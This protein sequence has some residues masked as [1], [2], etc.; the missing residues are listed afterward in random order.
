MYDCQNDS[1]RDFAYDAG[2]TAPTQ[3]TLKGTLA[4]SAAHTDHLATLEQLSQFA[5]QRGYPLRRQEHLLELADVTLPDA[6]V[7]NA[8]FGSALVI[9]CDLRCHPPA[10][11]A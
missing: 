6:L 9:S 4:A 11:F 7:I 2:H 8:R 1:C 3:S 5:H 10:R